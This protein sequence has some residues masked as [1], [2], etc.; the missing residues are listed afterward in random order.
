MGQP[1][2]GEPL[3]RLPDGTVKQVSPLTGTVVWTVPG[4]GRRAHAVPD[5]QRVAVDAAEHDRLCEFCSAR[6]LDTPPEKSRLVL[7]S[8]GP[9]VLEH[10]PAPR[11]GESVAELRRVPNLY[12]ILSVEYWRANHGYQPSPEL[13]G[14]ATAY[15]ADP[16]GRSHVL[17]M[18]GRRA[19]ATGLSG[20]WATEPEV[21][22]L[23]QAVDLFAG[24]HDVV[25]ARRHLVDGARYADELAGAGTLTPDEH[26][27]YLAFTVDAM[28]GLY[29][30][31]PF[32]RYVAVFQNWLRAAGASFDHLHKQLVAIDEFGPQTERELARLAAEPDVYT[33]AILDHAAAHRLVVAENEYAIAVAGVGHRYP[34][35]EVYSR[36]THHLPWEHTAAEVRG[37]SDLL[38]GLHAA[39]GV[40]VPTNEEWHYRPP[41]AAEP[42]PWHVVLKLRVSTLAGFEGGTKINVNT[43]D[44]YTLRDRTVAALRIL[45]EQGRVAAP[46][47]GDECSHDLGVLH[48]TD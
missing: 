6:Y 14:R 25:V 12:E 44:P 32:A 40:D 13:L 11:L 1:A 4:R 9:Q 5:Q 28:Q 7:T 17:D 39:T 46:A 36:S 15:T 33:T 24:S 34:A 41:S 29:R 43:I 45:R 10:L 21:E 20:V 37:F 47:I 8:D 16:L 42:M 22:R 31:Q 48:Y 38:H 2:S 18:L 3:V 23:A 30:A 27:R 19:A 35:L 26:E